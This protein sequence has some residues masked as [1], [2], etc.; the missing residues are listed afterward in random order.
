MA[1]RRPA[2]GFAAAN[3]AT[4]HGFTERAWNAGDQSVVSTLSQS[5][6]EPASAGTMRT[7]TLIP[8]GAARAARQNLGSGRYPG[9]GGGFV[10]PK[11]TVPSGVA[12]RAGCCRFWRVRD[13]PPAGVL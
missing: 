3:I 4:G 2:R 6:A 7:A 1:E 10:R 12:G 13:C 8:P 5:Q 9:P 11:R